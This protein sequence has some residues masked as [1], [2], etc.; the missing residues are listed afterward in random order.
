MMTRHPWQFTRQAVRHIQSSRLLRRLRLRRLLRLWPAAALTATLV[1]FVVT[2][3]GG[4]ADG[5][6]TAS[7]TSHIAEVALTPRQLTLHEGDTQRLTVTVRDINGAVIEGRPVRWAVVDTSVG[8]IAADGTVSAKR[9]GTTQVRAIVDGIVGSADLVVQPVPVA[10]ILVSL[11]PATLHVGQT[12]QATAVVRDAAGRSV[13]GR[14]V[15]WSSSDTR[16]FVV[17]STG[18]VT[19][20]APGNGFIVAGVENFQA[21]ASIAVLLVGPDTTAPRLVSLTF[22]PATVIL[23]GR[24]GHTTARAHVIDGGS[25]VDY[26]AIKLTGPKEGLDLNCDFKLEQG[27]ILDGTW[28]C[29]VVIPVGS[30]PGRWPFYY[31]YVQD[32]TGNYVSGFGTAAAALSPGI[33]VQP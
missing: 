6:G 33:T 9:T 20:V 26:L 8:A 3:C 7:P 12:A 25:G 18:R 23:G 19:A 14:L 15:K 31:W 2:A 17:D 24:E 4:N 27:T 13:A 10:S 1:G 16:R 29:D 11:S 28:S 21:A 22:T 32:A 30:P 5:T